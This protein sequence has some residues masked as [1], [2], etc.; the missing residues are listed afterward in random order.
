MA[1]LCT[2]EST[3]D[4]LGCYK[5]QRQ[6]H[7]FGIADEEMVARRC[8]TLFLLN[9]LYS[10]ALS[11]ISHLEPIFPSSL[12][13]ELE[14]RHRLISAEKFSHYKKKISTCLYS[15]LRKSTKTMMWCGLACLCGQHR[16]IKHWS[17]V[18]F[19]HCVFR[20]FEAIAASM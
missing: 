15:I 7:L 1:L 19:S 2:E 9:Y 20:I 10:S 13:F 17:V 8:P 14:N 4:T 3:L 5:Y 18:L 12:D 16:F 11:Q 6:R